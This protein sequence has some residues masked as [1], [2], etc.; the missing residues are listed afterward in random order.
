MPYGKG[1]AVNVPVVSPDI[2][3]KV[4]KKISMVGMRYTLED[5]HKNTVSVYLTENSIYGES[6]TITYPK[7]EIKPHRGGTGILRLI[8]L[9]PTRITNDPE[10]LL[11]D[12]V[13]DV[14]E[15]AKKM[16]VG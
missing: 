9:H 5:I 16:A 4:L 7:F 12:V 6:H 8:V 14:A 3:K 13:V 11:H 2:L 10:N 15:A 1:Y